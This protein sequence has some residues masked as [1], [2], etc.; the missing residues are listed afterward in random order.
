[1]PPG[2]SVPL[3]ALCRKRKAFLNRR[4]RRLQTGLNS[5]RDDRAMM[6]FTSFLAILAASTLLAACGG[7]GGS[8]TYTPPANGG[9]G[10]GG[11][12]GGQ[13]GAVLG[14]QTI[15]GGPAF[16]TSGGHAVYTFD[17]DTVADQSTCTGGCA[18]IWP[19]VRPPSGTL[20]APW[21]SFRRS[22]GS[23]QLAYNG[24]PLYTFVQDT[25]AG[26]ASGN[27]VEGFHIARPAN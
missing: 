15:D 11:A 2:S 26:E 12:G 16:V 3:A 22:D 14:T 13:N 8:T 25:R 9:T 17:G 10:A 4:A 1:L 21:S 18:A 20:S 19:P 27:G 5:V 24:K 7:G 23:M 6:K